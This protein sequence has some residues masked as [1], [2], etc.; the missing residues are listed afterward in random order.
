MSRGCE[1]EG[2]TELLCSVMVCNTDAARALLRA[3]RKRSLFLHSYHFYRK[4][5]FV[6]LFL[7][8]PMSESVSL[9][10]KAGV[11][12]HI[13]VAKLTYKLLLS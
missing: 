3:M 9:N 7:E 5:I 1:T 11:T 13:W 6:K 2:I 4:V 12:L 10:R 8:V